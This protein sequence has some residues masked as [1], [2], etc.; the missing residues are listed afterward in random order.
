MK[1]GSRVFYFIN[2]ALKDPTLSC[3]Y[4]GK[5]YKRISGRVIKIFKKGK[6]LT[7]IDIEKMFGALVGSDEFKK[8]YSS[9][10]SEIRAVM[11]TREGDRHILLESMWT[12]NTFG[13]DRYVEI[14]PNNI[15]FLYGD[16]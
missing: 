9:R 15:D 3:K 16:D 2:K 4:G 14:V 8:L 1:E 13:D 5:S 12:N 6:R 10:T 7:A 11:E